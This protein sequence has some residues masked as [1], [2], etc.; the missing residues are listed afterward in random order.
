MARDRLVYIIKRKLHGVKCTSMSYLWSY[1]EILGGVG[2]ACCFYNKFK[3]SSL[4]VGVHSLKYR[5]IM[6]NLSSSLL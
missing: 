4:I 3:H 2:S 1:Q 6:K 5:K